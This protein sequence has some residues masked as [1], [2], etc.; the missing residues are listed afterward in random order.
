MQCRPYANRSAFTKLASV[1][2]TYNSS[3]MTPLVFLPGT[4][5]DERL[6]HYQSAIF[7]SHHHVNLRTQD[8]LPAML[9]EVEKAPFNEFIICGFSMGGY[10]AQQFAL[11][12]PDRV[13][14]VVTIGS[15]FLGYP[16]HE[17]A[18]VEKAIPMIEKG[19]FKGITQRR[20]KE[21]LHPDSFEK[22]EL[23]D[24]IQSMAGPDAAAV[25]LRQL[26][27]T[28]YRNNLADKITQLKP[29]LTAIGGKQDQVVL[30]ETI[31]EFKKVL[32]N[33]NVIL[34]DGCGHFVPLEKP[35]QVNEILKAIAQVH[36]HS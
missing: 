4:L 34:L 16:A 5:C 7:E 14:H 10:V 35:N 25:Y 3:T 20:M 30:P 36:D 13:K 31:L 15:S 9:A 21:F 33:S 28:L 24:L 1:P 12:F 2:K 26:K 29:P 17:L 27:A 18:V 32:P 19:L 22:A 23:R 8:N 11:R 6:W